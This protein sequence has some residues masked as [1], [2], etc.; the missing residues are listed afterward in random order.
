MPVMNSEA[1][2]ERSYADLLMNVTIGLSDGLLVP[3]ALCAG[4]TGAG[5][6]SEAVLRTGL[7]VVPVAALLMGTGGWLTR[8]NAA[9]KP[10]NPL[11]SDWDQAGRTRE[12]T[13]NFLSGLGMDQQMQDTAIAEMENDDR[14]WARFIGQYDHETISREKTSAPLAGLLIG[15]SYLLAGSLIVA[16]YAFQPASSAF[17]WCSLLV[18]IMLLILGIIRG[19]ILHLNSVVEILKLLVTA[20]AA[21]AAA[22]M[23]CRLIF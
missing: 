1:T 10:A 11:T 7:I 5:L 22:F 15:F 12:E 9:L 14:T 20:A 4:M 23:I 2:T 8:K 16:P 21:G 6:A 17:R 18:A 13:R 3:F 19:R